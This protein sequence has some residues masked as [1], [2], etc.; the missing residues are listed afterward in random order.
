[1]RDGCSFR[2]APIITKEIFDIVDTEKRNPRAL[3]IAVTPLLEAWGEPLVR[4][5]S[6]PGFGMTRFVSPNTSPSSLQTLPH[7]NFDPP[8]S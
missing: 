2:A 5:D 8:G 7:G 3:K 6:L 4:E 1:M